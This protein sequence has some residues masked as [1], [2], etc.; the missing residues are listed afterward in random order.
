MQFVAIES[1]LGRGLCYGDFFF[2]FVFVCF[3][4]PRHR[5]IKDTSFLYPF[6]I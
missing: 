2:L 5:N 6:D 3:G 4:N 1:G